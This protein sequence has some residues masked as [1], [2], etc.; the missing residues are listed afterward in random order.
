[1]SLAGYHYRFPSAAVSAAAESSLLLALWSVESLH[2]AEQVR[3]DAALAIDA[4]RRGFLI[5]ADT[6]VGR[7]LNLM[8]AGYIR[9]SVGSDA[10]CVERLIVETP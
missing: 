4:D 1:M 10:Y 7:D 8:F 9:R 6:P 5:A 2:G 3:L